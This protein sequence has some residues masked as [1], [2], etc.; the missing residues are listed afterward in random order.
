LAFGIGFFWRPDSEV[1]PQRSQILE[2]EKVLPPSK[3]GM[4]RDSRIAEDY[5]KYFAATGSVRKLEF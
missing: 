5:G 1:L 2:D 4:S 3:F